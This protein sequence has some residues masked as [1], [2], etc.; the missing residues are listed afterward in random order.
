[1]KW[2]R[3]R[4]VLERQHVSHASINLIEYHGTIS[5]MLVISFARH[6]PR[7]ELRRLDTSA[8]LVEHSARSEPHP[9]LP[10]RP[11]G[12]HLLFSCSSSPLKER[13]RGLQWIRSAKHPGECP[14]SE[15]RR[16][17]KECRSR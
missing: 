8:K 13:K 4:R 6:L 15:E 10:F 17:G 2:G 12:C 7:F 5:A 14:R 16:V 9:H 1:M 11:R 3:R